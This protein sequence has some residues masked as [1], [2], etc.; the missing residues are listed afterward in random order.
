MAPRVH[1]DVVL[2]HVLALKE[3]GGG[4]CARAN[5]K[6][7][8]LEGMLVQ[9][10]QEIGCV[11]CGTV[12]VCETPGVLGW[13]RCNISA[14]NAPTARPPATAGIC[15]SGGVGCAPSSYGGIKAWNLNAGRLD[16]GDPF[17]NLWA[18]GGGDG[19]KLR[20]ISGGKQCSW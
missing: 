11:E 18:V 16:L 19:V 13:A 17:L 14:A 2:G 6:E 15:D 10:S 20:V 12:V 3:G 1:G 8:G 7:R 4:N 5:D 9:V